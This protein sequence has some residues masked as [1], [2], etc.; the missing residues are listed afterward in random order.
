MSYTNLSD[1]FYYDD[2]NKYYSRYDAV[3]KSSDP[4]KLK[5]YFYDN[6]FSSFDWTKE[7]Q[8]SLKE[9]YKQRAE[10]LRA[11]YDYLVLCYSGGIDSTNMLESFYYNNIH[12]DE[13]LVVG[14]FSKD[15]DSNS[16]ENHNLEIYRNVFPVLS[17]MNLIDTSINV[18]DY[19]KLFERPNQLEITKYNDWPMHIGTHFSPHNFFW[20][21]VEK[22]ILCKKPSAS[23]GILFGADKPLITRS[24]EAY[25]ND[26]G[27][28]GYGRTSLKPTD[29]NVYKV[30]FYTD[31][32]AF[33]LMLKQYHILK[34][35]HQKYKKIKD[36]KIDSTS[37]T[38]KLIYKVNHP[39]SFKSA[40][41]PTLLYSLRDQYLR[42]ATNT[43]L[44]NFYTNGLNSIHCPKKA[45]FLGEGIIS[46]KKYSLNP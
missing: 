7:P 33:N 42:K 37:I 13:I 26:A 22:H 24:S 4:S 44:F 28:L 41:S 1:V 43:S 15:I 36:S 3:I 27:C 12:I 2:S 5:F 18:I 8:E 16:D 39:L 46:T 20:Y 45:A 34:N 35:F 40:K 25:F 29:D 19:V 17:D 14:A 6:I 31:P 9:L 21:E 11:K 38:E 30:N 10:Y 32:E 23:V